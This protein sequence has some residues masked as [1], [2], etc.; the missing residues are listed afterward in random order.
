MK[1]FR[2]LNAFFLHLRLLISN[3]ILKYLIIIL[4][5]WVTTLAAQEPFYY[6]IDKSKG[7]PSNTV[8]DIF[9][10]S[11]GFIWFA[12][13]NGLSRYDGYRFKHYSSEKQTL[14][15][16]SN[17]AE[18]KYGRIWY[19][20]FDGYMYYVENDTLKAFEHSAMWTFLKF[21]VVG[22]RL[23]CV[24]P[25]AIVE[26]NLNTLKEI[27]RTNLNTE[28]ILATIYDKHHFYVLAEKL[29]I[30]SHS[31]EVTSMEL[32][33]DF[34]EKT[35]SPLLEIRDNKIVISL[36]NADFFYIRND[37]GWERY[38]FNFPPKFIQNLSSFD[39]DLW[40]CTTAGVIR[41]HPH[42][43][44][45]VYDRFFS[46]FNTTRIFKDKSG[47]F[48]IATNGQGVL[49]IGS[50]ET[51]FHYFNSNINVLDISR[52]MLLMG[53]AGDMVQKMSLKSEVFSTF[54]KG[55]A[56]HETYLLKTFDDDDLVFL[57]SNRFKIVDMNGKLLEDLDLA[58]KDICRLRDGRYAIAATGFF[59]LI[60]MK[61]KEP[62]SNIIRK[63]NFISTDKLY[64][65]QVFSNI[66]GKSVAY[67]PKNNRVFFSA[68]TGLFVYENDSV[69]EILNAKGEKVFFNQIV[70]FRDELWSVSSVGN[71]YRMDVHFNI[72]PA[73][74]NIEN[75]AQ[76]VNRIRIANDNLYFL[77][78]R[79][80]LLFDN[81]TESV[82]KVLSISS[83][84]SVN[85]VQ[86]ANDM[87][88]VATSRG[89]IIQQSGVE[90]KTDA[91]GLVIDYL[92]AGGKKI[93]TTKDYMRFDNS[94]NDI[95]IYYSIISFDPNQ[96]R[97]LYYSING[98][99]WESIVDER[100]SLEFRN[101]RPGKYHIRLMSS[102]GIRL[103]PEIHL[104]FRIKPPFWLQWWFIAIFVLL[105]ILVLY[106]FDRWRTTS[107]Q[108]KSQL[109]IDRI[110]LEKTA[111]QSKLKAL[112]SQM[113]PHFFFNALN[114]IQSFILEDNKKQAVNV[115]SKFSGLTRS[116]LEMS[117]KDD[118]TVAE[119]IKVLRLY[120][121][122]EKVRFNEDFHYEINLKNIDPDEVRIPSLLLQPYVENAIKHGLLHKQGDK[123]LKINFEISNDLFEISIRDNGIGR[124]MSMELN[125]IKTQKHKSYAS[126]AMAQ[127]VRL[128]N[129]FDGRK[130]SLKYIDEMS[131]SGQALGTT[132]KI[133]IP[134]GS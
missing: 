62:A 130:I 18:D 105:M 58:V 26:Y 27:R 94:Q 69:S 15:A 31:G 83:E 113:N 103:S 88:Y 125:A 98:S 100:Q 47:A 29:Y 41:A 17:I 102:N 24:E 23:F 35:P 77:T 120:L 84:L 10:D 42:P 39:E 64:I 50:F 86:E 127:R 13:G 20:N 2:D 75:I 56:G 53:M 34:P 14:K 51:T 12:S 22:D 49:Y 128:L 28:K 132:V 61:D 123:L 121:D 43:E 4:S 92:T 95:S 129:E 48:W 30:Y 106:R 110:N 46:H 101:L 70:F 117:E 3:I 72:K 73:N 60:T 71:V 131:E 38:H 54:H 63:S 21:G 104:H 107:I 36:K 25:R 99:Y 111:N 114:T 68:N 115:L 93:I 37:L 118:V 8:Y 40:F 7:L 59:A 19:V 91:P 80:L 44:G 90:I 85:D 78:D 97:T 126:D 5:I 116:M 89:L 65:E 55:N 112:K 96:T 82:R 45:F 109:I 124:K 16:G 9:Q 6:R 108:T 122:I 67:D 52:D 119:E 81:P 133:R 57:T 66:R 74:I 32:P 87:L 79:D 76:K 134:L 33:A 11:K 1:P